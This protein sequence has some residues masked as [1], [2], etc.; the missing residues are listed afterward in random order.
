[1]SYCGQY[2]TKKGQTAGSG[3]GRYPTKEGQTAWFGLR[4][5]PNEGGADRM[6]TIKPF[7]QVAV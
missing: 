5:V 2:P 1:M 4:S 6:L 7:T 3:C